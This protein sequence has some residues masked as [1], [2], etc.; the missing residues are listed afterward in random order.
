MFTA[1]VDETGHELERGWTFLAGF[2]GNEDQWSNF[3][4]KWRV[5][6]GPQRKS[7]HMSSLRWNNDSTRRLLARLGPIPEE[8]CLRPIMAGVRFEDYADLVS[9]KPYKKQLKGYLTCLHALVIQVLR[10]IPGDERLEM[11]FEEQGEYE[12]FANLVLAIA[13]QQGPRTSEGLPKLAKWSFV[14]KGSTIMT[15][16]SDYFAFALAKIWSDPHSKKAKW[17]YPILNS[18]QGIGYGKVMQKDEI[19]PIITDI[20]NPLFDNL[21]VQSLER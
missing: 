17:C 16:P 9:G 1:Y 3:V 5:G 13:A 14:P 15:D 19:R 8:C 12:P 2:L 21:D 11:V 18:G 6:L 10:V 7:L 20:V 4:P